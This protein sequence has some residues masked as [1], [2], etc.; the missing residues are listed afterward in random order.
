MSKAENNSNDSDFELETNINED[1]EENFESS[2]ET[3]KTKINLMVKIVIIG[4]VLY[5]SKNQQDPSPEYRL[6]GYER[7][8]PLK[9]R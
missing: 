2:D 6:P 1:N 5:L 4:Q 3:N 8:V 9:K 7:V